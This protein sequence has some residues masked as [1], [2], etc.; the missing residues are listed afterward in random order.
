MLKHLSHC[1]HEF[2]FDFYYTGWMFYISYSL[3]SFWSMSAKTQLSHHVPSW[4]S[5]DEWE[6]WSTGGDKVGSYL[7]SNNSKNWLQF[8]EKHESLCGVS[9]NPSDVGHGLRDSGKFQPRFT[10]NTILLPVTSP[11]WFLSF[12]FSKT[13]TPTMRGHGPPL[14]HAVCSLSLVAQE[15]YFTQWRAQVSD[16]FVIRKWEQRNWAA[17]VKWVAALLFCGVNLSPPPYINTVLSAQ[18]I[19]RRLQQYM[20]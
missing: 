10:Q 6:D 1:N 16:V 4:W 15:F 14:P 19:G 8:F 12:G 20:Q 3:L 2:R 9:G 7:L 13:L 11:S 17:N 18:I 5:E